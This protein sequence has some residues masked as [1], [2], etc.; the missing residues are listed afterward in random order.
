M[1]KSSAKN[2]VSP[3]T[4]KPQSSGISLFIL[5]FIFRLL[6]LIVG[7]G[8]GWVLGIT[9]ASKFPSTSNKTPLLEQFFTRS[10]SFTKGIG[11]VTSSPS[12]MPVSPTPIPN[13][14]VELT[15]EKRE[16]IKGEL[17]QLQGDLNSLI[18]RTTNLESQL[19]SRRPTESLE[20]RIE[21]ISQQLATET[22]SSNS[23]KPASI[24]PISMTGEKQ[25]TLAGNA[26]MVTFPSDVLFEQDS[27]SIKEGSNVILDNLIAELR[28]YPGATVRIGVHTDNTGDFKQSRAL[29]FARAQL[30]SQYLSQ[31]LG[32]EYY[33][34]IIGYGSSRPTVEN[35][36]DSNRQ[37]NRRVEISITPK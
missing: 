13:I 2:S 28:N 4:G 14:K 29:S 11:S 7:G 18:G 8:L 37:R 30:V 31:V 25:Q 36:S 34:I 20:K 15:P 9:I 35:A 26:L 12:V 10:G 21:I 5:S 3:Q 27:T 22:T 19:G 33:W 32:N 24:P 16:K 6:L 23:A 1:T 17:K